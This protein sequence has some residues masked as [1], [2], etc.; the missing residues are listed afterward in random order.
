METMRRSGRDRTATIAPLAFGALTY[1]LFFAL[2][3]YFIGFLAAELV[4]RSVDGG[5][6]VA[7]TGAA[8]VVDTALFLL[9]A[10]SHS[11]LAR[12]VV[13]SRLAG[14][15]PSHLERS[16]YVL[17]ATS[18]LALLFWQWRPI[19]EVVWSTDGAA[20][21]ALWAG[22]GVG[23]LVVVLSTFLINHFDL[24]GL[25]QVYLHARA[26]EYQ[27]IGFRTPLLYR[28]VRHPMML[29]F[30]LVVWCAPTMTVGHVLFAV[31]FTGYIL[32][33]VQLEE[34][35]LHSSLPGYADY[36]TRVPQ[37]VPGLRR[38]RARAAR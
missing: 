10:V 11:A 36:A 26:L 9:F 5:G 16:V 29:G 19:P 1:L 6:P 12:P 30:V 21:T 33:A 32:V 35:D 15:V 4:P 37:L 18:T 7:A 24:F 2:L 27:P 38:N 28:I 25:R 8:V 3:L 13:K 31:L 23:W 20:A 34:R 22:Y 14:F 17:V